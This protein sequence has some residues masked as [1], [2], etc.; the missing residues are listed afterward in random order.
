MCCTRSLLLGPGFY[1]TVQYPPGWSVRW[2]WDGLAVGVTQRK[3][4]TSD[5]SNTCSIF[6]VFCIQ[7]ALV[8]GCFG[9]PVSLSMCVPQYGYLAAMSLSCPIIMTAAGGFQSHT[10]ARCKWPSKEPRCSAGRAE[11]S[12][13][14]NC[15]A[16][17]RLERNGLP[18]LVILC[19]DW[20]GEPH[21]NLSGVDNR[22]RAGVMDHWT[23]PSQG[24]P[25]WRGNEEERFQARPVST[26]FRGLSS[27]EPSAIAL[28]ASGEE[29]TL[30]D[31]NGSR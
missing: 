9:I 19:L 6:T 25:R 29:L 30:A 2:V 11:R 24:W 23:G 26:R 20:T 14:L 16:C 18:P 15:C 17:W 28:A 22:R 13:R 21:A 27:G 31:D 8:L 10:R 12:S 5:R 3:S 4:W 1:T 7:L